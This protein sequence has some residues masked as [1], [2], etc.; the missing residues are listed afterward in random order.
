M[1]QDGGSPSDGLV[2][3]CTRKGAYIGRVLMDGRLILLHN[4]PRP[5]DALQV[6]HLFFVT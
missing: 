5:P 2:L 4:I 1:L 3:M 6:K